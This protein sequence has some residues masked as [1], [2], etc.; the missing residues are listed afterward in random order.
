[1]TPDIQWLYLLPLLVTFGAG[2]VGILVESFVRHHE[3]RRGIQ[4][5]LT[6]AAILGALASV[7]GLWITLGSDSSV[8]IDGSTIALDSHSLLW[9]GLI[10]LFALMS[11]GVFTARTSGED[12]FVPLAASTPGS[13][14]EALASRRGM[15]QTEVYP[16]MLFAVGGMMMFTM[17]QD[18]FALFVVLEVFSLPLYLL[19]G[20]ARRRRLLSQEAAL[21]YFLTGA[22]ASA[23][24]LFGAALVFGFAGAS[25][26]QAIASALASGAPSQELV[27]LGS[28]LMLVGLLFKLGAAP[29][30]AWTPDA[31]QG[32]PTAVTGFMAAATKAAAV[33]ALV[34]LVYL[35]FAPEQEALGIVFP[36]DTVVWSLVAF[37]VVSMVVGT[38]MALAQ[39]DI[40][41]ILAYSSIAHAGFLL[42]AV[43]SFTQ[44]ALQAL[45]FYMAVYGIATVGAFAVVSLVRH[46]DEDGAWGA[47]ASALEH[48][49]GLGRRSPFIAGAMTLFLF[50]FAGIPLTAG[51]VGKFLAF[52]AA[53]TDPSNWWLVAI[54]VV[55]SAAAAFFYAR[56][57]VAM[58]FRETP[59]GSVTGI[60]A[61]R[62]VRVVIAIAAVL[63]ILLGVFPSGA[64]SLA[65][66]GAELFF[67]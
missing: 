57:V 25:S 4:I 52:R 49:A 63:T 53:L 1:M 15:L 12:A 17:V 47:E 33:A 30:H 37:A 3:N 29:F 43:S 65:E 5:A 35:A 54:A 59:A 44:E 48:W 9:Q 7:V 41:R 2:V 19:V 39:D 23:V 51:F 40:K 66:T 6:V 56:V 31:Y 34:R 21:K 11:I 18:I 20:L 62:T 32:A 45:P 13:S 58:F 36:L 28:A 46:R 8:S 27:V 26:Y 60:T 61:G 14:D 50:S 67:L 10:A 64:L 24:Y 38:V 42:V 55:M 22:F 16:L